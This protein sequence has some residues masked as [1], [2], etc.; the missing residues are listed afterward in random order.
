MNQPE[1]LTEKMSSKLD[2]DQQM[3]LTKGEDLRNILMIGGI[4]IFLPFA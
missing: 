3:Q 4:Q 1:E 2:S